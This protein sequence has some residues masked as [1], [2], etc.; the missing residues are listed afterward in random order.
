[1]LENKFSH[2][3][4]VSF[5]LACF[6]SSS[7]KCC[8][9]ATVSGSINSMGIEPNLLR[10]NVAKVWFHI[11]LC[12]VWEFSHYMASFYVELSILVFRRHRDLNLWKCKKHASRPCSVKGL[13]LER[14]GSWAFW[15]G[16]AS[17]PYAT[18][19]VLH[20]EQIP[21]VAG[22]LNPEEPGR[23]TISPMPK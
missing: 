20:V 14:E 6:L 5:L 21:L 22:M 1:M 12:Q 7:L 4:A 8:C 11:C 3:L 2:V 16:Y 19:R 18:S 10:G 23:K 15:K 13:G 17:P 9:E